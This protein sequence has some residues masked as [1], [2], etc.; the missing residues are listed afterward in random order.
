M[1]SP[2]RDPQRFLKGDRLDITREAPGH[3]A[4]G[5]G[6][7]YCVGAPLARIEARIA[8][9]MLIGRFPDIRL[10]ASAE[11]LTRTPSVIMNG[12][13]TLPVHLRRHS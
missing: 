3:V 7:H 2:H 1:T 5:H 9:S 10:A 4:F 13:S 8:I 11:S 12:L 6:I